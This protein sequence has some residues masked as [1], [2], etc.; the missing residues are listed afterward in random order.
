MATPVVPSQFPSASIFFRSLEHSS[1]GTYWHVA[2]RLN[3]FFSLGASC[4][5]VLQMIGNDNANI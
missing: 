3:H 5:H 4:R 2:N 1:E